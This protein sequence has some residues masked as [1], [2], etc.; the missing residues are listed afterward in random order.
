MHMYLGNYCVFFN[1]IINNACI[2]FSCIDDIP[3]PYA[4]D[5]RC[6]FGHCVR[7]YDVCDGY[8][9]CPDGSDEGMN[10]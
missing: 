2:T 8:E 6:G 5:F 1:S 4:G 10:C 3:C 9:E 7:G